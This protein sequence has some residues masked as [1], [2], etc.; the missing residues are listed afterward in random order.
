MF[1]QIGSIQG[2]RRLNNHT[3]DRFNW[4]TVFETVEFRERT[5]LNDWHRKITRLYDCESP[6][7]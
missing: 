5:N 4:W 3:N 6:V 2:H 7:E 1:M